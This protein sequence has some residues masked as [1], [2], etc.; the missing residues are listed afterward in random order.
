MVSLVLLYALVWTVF[1]VG[2]IGMLVPGIVSLSMISTACPSPYKYDSSSSKCCYSTVC[3]AFQDYMTPGIV[4]LC[5][6]F[7]TGIVGICLLCKASKFY[8]N[9]NDTCC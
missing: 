2:G 7:V 8:N 3:I 6:G 5:I 9:N 1:I 4:L